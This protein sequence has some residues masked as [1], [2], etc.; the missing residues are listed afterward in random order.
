MREFESMGQLDVYKLGPKVKIMKNG[1]SQ[2]KIK[3]QIVKISSLSKF[4]FNSQ[5]HRIECTIFH[6]FTSNFKVILKLCVIGHAS[7]I[8]GKSCNIVKFSN[9]Y[10]LI[11]LK[12]C[13]SKTVHSRWGKSTCRP[14]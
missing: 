9:I 2:K 11:T 13:S 10:D 6:N 5:L 3:E 4:I 1:T 8:G 12:G 7:Y 14:M